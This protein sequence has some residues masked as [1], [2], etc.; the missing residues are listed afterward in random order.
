[1]ILQALHRCSKC[2]NYKPNNKSPKSSA[3]GTAVIP[4][5]WQHSVTKPVRSFKYRTF[6]TKTA[7][8]YF[9][10]NRVKSNFI[11]ISCRA[12]NGVQFWCEVFWLLMWFKSQPLR[13]LNKFLAKLRSLSYWERLMVSARKWLFQIVL[14]WQWLYILSHWT[15][16]S[17][18]VTI[19]FWCS[20]RCILLFC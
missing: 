6:S 4:F 12:W 7:P 20:Q 3:Q 16:R 18:T 13:H 15:F 9:W 8:T 17:V 2:P 10:F 19:F 1:M 5:R 14:R 11:G